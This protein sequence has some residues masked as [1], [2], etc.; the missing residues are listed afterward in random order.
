MLDCEANLKLIKIMIEGRPRESLVL[1]D[2]PI[3]V[4]FDSNVAGLIFRDY[5]AQVFYLVYY[6][7]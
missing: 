2:N 5:K 6:N 1:Y 4:R 3:E 7:Y